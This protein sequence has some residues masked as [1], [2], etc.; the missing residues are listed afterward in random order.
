MLQNISGTI[1]QSVT[2]RQ[3]CS[4]KSRGAVSQGQVYSSTNSGQ[5]IVFALEYAAKPAFHPKKHVANL[6][7]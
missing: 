5:L 2:F 7:T 3:V 4:K 6:Q 1:F